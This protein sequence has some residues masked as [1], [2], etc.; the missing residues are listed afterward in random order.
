MQVKRTEL[1]GFGGPK[2][3]EELVSWINRARNEANEAYRE[4]AAVVYGSTRDGVRIS[5]LA[6]RIAE[7][8]RGIANLENALNQLEARLTAGGL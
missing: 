5:G 4:L 2:R 3:Q 6:D 8:Q 1:V 7:T